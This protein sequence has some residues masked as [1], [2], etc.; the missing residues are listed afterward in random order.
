MS[1]SP[2][3][4][5]RAALLVTTTLSS[6][7]YAAAAMAQAPAGA[8]QLEEVVVTATRQSDT[9]NRVPLSITAETQRALDQQG[10]KN[11]ADLT[12]TVP[13]LN[14]NQL[15]PGTS[16]VTIRGIANTTTANTAPTTGF[17]LDDTPIQ[18]RNTGGGVATSNG[19]PLPPLFD[20]ERVEVLRGPQGTLYGGSSEGGT[21]RY[22]TPQPSLTR[23]SE[24]VRGEVSQTHDGGTNYEAGAAIGGPIIADKL[25][26]RVSIFGR[27]DAGFID[28]VDPL[29]QKVTFPDANSRESNQFRAAVT[30]APTDRMRI[31]AAYL[32]SRDHS[33]SVNFTY[34]L[35]TNAPIVEPTTCFN[36]ASFTQANFN[37]SHTNPA[38]VAYG[39]AACA[40]ATAAGAANYTRPGF[41]YGPYNFSPYQ[42][43]STNGKLPSTTL[44]SLPTLTAEYDFEHMTFKSITSL[45][46]DETKSVN[47]DQSQITGRLIGTSYTQPGGSGAGAT[48]PFS[49]AGTP[50]TSVEGSYGPFVVRT[51]PGFIGGY[52]DFGAGNGHFF[53]TNERHG[54]SQ[55]FRFAS[56]GDA[57]PLS[58]VLGTFYSLYN[59]KS[60]YQ[61]YYDLA[62][63]SNLLYG[64]TPQQRYGVEPL[65]AANGTPT[66][67]DYH[68]QNLRDTEVAGFGEINYWITDKFKVTGGVR[69]SRV[70]FNYSNYE[71]GSG[72]GFNIPTVANGGISN[73]TNTSSPITPKI[74]AEWQ[75]NDK[76]M[77]YVSASKGFR[78]GGVNV[79]L[80]PNIC[81]TGLGLVGLTVNDVKPTYDPDSVWSYEAGT[82]LRLLSNRVQLNMDAYRIDW[83]HVQ[84]STAIGCGVPF[85]LNGNTARSQGAELESQILVARGL[86]ANIAVGYDN[87]KYTANAYGPTPAAGFPAVIVALKDQPFPIAPWTVDI[88]VRYEHEIAPRMLG[89]IRGDYRY[90]SHYY[91]NVFGQATYS[92]DTTDGIATNRTNM[93]LGVEY[94]GFDINFFANNLFNFDKGN[95]AGGRATC[96]NAPSTPACPNYASYNALETETTVTPRVIGFQIAYR[97]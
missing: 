15:A 77:V 23:Y 6:A 88:G 86:T 30:W 10:I 45:V 42:A 95:I 57:K 46:G 12:A 18:K 26:F 17:Y 54:M 84:I 27:K 37:A 14:V 80:S 44:I 82:K 9:V 89:Y 60:I 66:L 52:P 87:A 85:V 56:A 5:A 38:P 47:S 25:G 75:I 51:G 22:I 65:I 41:T 59:G 93:R 28:L 48:A 79:Y 61:I 11:I 92:P 49:P 67:F 90:S 91:N 96:T 36:T 78:S 13:A 70:Q 94:N 7:L 72:N 32:T 29:T 4:R 43:L 8:G 62:R 64:I 58:W 33:D 16:Q 68:T 76:D 21:I 97:H 71:I 19:T 2:L 63:I 1:Q 31:T 24:Y 40:T 20:L 83:S 73:G 55:E 35:S 39:A 74:A 50:L 81:G 34:N 69:W 3:R 53:S